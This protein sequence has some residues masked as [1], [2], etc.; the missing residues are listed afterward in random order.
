MITDEELFELE[1]LVND[2]EIF[3]R[4]ESLKNHFKDKNPNYTFISESF[5]AQ[6][7][8][9]KKGKTEL[10]SGYRGVIL[11]GSSRSGKT[12]S[13]IDFLIYICLFYGKKL[14]INIIKETYNEFKTTLY[15]D[16]RERLDYYDLPNPFYKQE[17][18][19]FRINGCKINLIGADAKQGKSNKFHGAACDILYFNELI[20]ISQAVFDQSEMRCRMFWIGDY[21]PSVTEHYVFKSVIPRNDVG[22]L[23]TTFKENPHISIQERQKILSYEPWKTDSYQV[24]DGVIMYLGQ[25]VT[26]KN[27]PPLHRENVEQG[28]ADEFMWKVYGLGLRGAMKGQIFKHITWI[29]NFPN[30]AFTY[31]LDF[32]FTNDETA[33]VK[34]AREGRNIYMELLIYQP[35]ITPEELSEGLKAVGVTKYIPITAD[36]ADRYVSE[37]HGVIQMVRSLFDMGWEISKVSKVKSVIFWLSDMKGYK[38]HIVENHLYHKFKSEQEN[39]RFKEIN[40]ILINQPIDGYDHAFSAGRYAHMSH[41][42]DNLSVNYS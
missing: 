16:F 6:K 30:L 28:T 1:K 36:S 37:R 4:R 7:Y 11:E 15:D 24:I 9:D 20:A 25:P 17:V 32:G 12:Y 42:I 40:G 8:E 14:V 38:I 35:I 33:L 5:K 21:N 18:H 41:D 22:F 34:Y 10:V 39:Y 19:N 2:Q 29:K 26:E 27:Q 13:T 31:G 23:R 3:E